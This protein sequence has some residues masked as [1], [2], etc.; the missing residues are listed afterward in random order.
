MTEQEALSKLQKLCSRQEKCIYDVKQRLLA[1]DITENK[2]DSIIKNLLAGRFIDE[3]RYAKGFVND[4]FRF[5]K[6]GKAKIAYHLGQKRIDGDI[7][8]EA[9]EQI[10]EEDYRNSIIAILRKKRNTMKEQDTS[11]VRQKLIRFAQSK[12]FDYGTVI[13]SVQVIMKDDK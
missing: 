10:D 4:K 1:W 7:I 11:L 5:S 9:L 8:K 12:G 3:K 13:Q 2:S 6:W